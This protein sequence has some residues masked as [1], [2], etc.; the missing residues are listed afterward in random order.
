MGGNYGWH[1][2]EH[3][4]FWFQLTISLTILTAAY[5]NGEIKIRGWVI[6]MVAQTVF[7][8]YVVLT[9]QWGLIPNNV[10]MWLIAL[11]NFRKWKRLGIGFTP[12]APKE[13]L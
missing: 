10:G 2:Y 9:Q 4:Q 3:W 6:L 1:F 8:T 12:K 11:R 13:A 7:L 5:F